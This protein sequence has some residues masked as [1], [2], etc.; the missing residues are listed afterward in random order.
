MDPRQL[1]VVRILT[2]GAGLVLPRSLFLQLPFFN[3]MHRF[4]PSLVRRHGSAVIGVPVAHR[5]RRL[6]TQIPYT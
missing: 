1:A 4:M 2:P 5:P 3:H 6:A